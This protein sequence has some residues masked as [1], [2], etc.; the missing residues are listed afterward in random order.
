MILWTGYELPLALSVNQDL[1]GNDLQGGSS[2]QNIWMET[3]S[4]ELYGE[5]VVCI[6]AVSSSSNMVLVETVT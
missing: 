3:A 6:G 4:L 5:F 1:D 2:T